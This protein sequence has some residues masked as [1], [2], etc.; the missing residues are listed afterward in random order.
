M[1]AS[2]AGRARAPWSCSPCWR[3]L[4]NRK[5]GGP[6]T[7]RRRSKRG[8]RRSLLHGQLS[9]PCSSGR[10][11][12][13]FQRR[14]APAGPPISVFCANAPRIEQM[15]TGGRGEQRCPHHFGVIVRR[16]EEKTIQQHRNS[17]AELTGVVRQCDGDHDFEGLRSPRR[18][19]IELTLI[20]F[21]V[22]RNLSAIASP[23]HP[24]VK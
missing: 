21:T 12:A 23:G 3:R 14:R 18:K 15:R 13:N 24:P 5:V 22:L 16:G 17:V 8:N 10:R 6:A 9:S 2:R 1:Q 11:F 4:D 19:R 20:R 7:A